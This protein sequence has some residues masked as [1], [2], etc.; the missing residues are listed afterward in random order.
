MSDITELEG[1]ITAALERIG[2]GVEAISAERAAASEEEKTNPAADPEALAR[3]KEVLEAEKTANAQL[4]ERV[5]AIREKQEGHI[6]QL[7]ARVETLTA[8]A[9]EAEARVARLRR[10]NAELREN[11][12]ALRAANAKGLGD[13]HLINKSMQAELETLRAL[14]DSDRSE[15]DALIDELAPLAGESSNA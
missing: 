6:R 14:R 13:A 10:V 9:E 3:M 12:G 5:R 1:R 15:L 11:N 8:R 7:E 4:E 2:R